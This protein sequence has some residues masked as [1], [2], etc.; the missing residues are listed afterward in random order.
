ME[1]RALQY[2]EPG[3]IYLNRKKQ[4]LYLAIG[5]GNHSE[6]AQNLVVYISAESLATR[7]IVGRMLLKWAI[8]LLRR[9]TIWIRPLM[10]FEEK[11]MEA[12]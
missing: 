2:V 5:V 10:L 4:T 9:E 3:K 1:T 6:S 7:S 11:F 12:E 8:K